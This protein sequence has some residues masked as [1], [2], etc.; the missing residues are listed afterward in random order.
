MIP[1]KAAPDNLKINKNEHKTINIIIDTI[2]NKFKADAVGSPVF[3]N[4]GCGNRARS[5][6]V[7]TRLAPRNGAGKSPVHLGD[8][9][10]STK[11]PGLSYRKYY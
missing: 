6:E 10:T 1:G 3:W 7:K 9:S 11:R 8:G 4:A 2:D 5:G